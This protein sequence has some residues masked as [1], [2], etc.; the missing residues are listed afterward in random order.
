[1]FKDAQGLALTPASA[2]AVAGFDHTM[3]GY[4]KYRADT[5]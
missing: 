1:M 5:S 2:E 4:L 3:E